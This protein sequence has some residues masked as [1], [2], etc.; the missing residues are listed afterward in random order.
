[1]WLIWFVWHWRAILTIVHLHILRNSVGI[2]YFKFHCVQQQCTLHRLFQIFLIVELLT[3]W[4]EMETNLVF[5]FFS[6]EWC[7]V[8]CAILTFRSSISLLH[9]F[10]FHITQIVD[11]KLKN[12]E[13]NYFMLSKFICCAYIF[14]TLFGIVQR[15]FVLT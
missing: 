2:V 9:V 3:N 12:P 7:V 14:L 10:F 1:M 6:S 5:I 4:T 13:E 15:K 8:L 11:M